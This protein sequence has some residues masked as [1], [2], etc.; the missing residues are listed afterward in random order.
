MSRRQ[1]REPYLGE[2]DL[3][4]K[5]ALIQG[6]TRG[7]AGKKRELTDTENNCCEDFIFLFLHL[8]RYPVFLMS[9]SALIY[10]LGNWAQRREYSLPPS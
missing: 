1:I 10:S 8:P 6:S 9:L 7:E 5:S 3:R 4:A 2:E